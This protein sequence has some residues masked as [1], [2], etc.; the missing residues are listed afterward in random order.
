MSFLVALLISA[1]LGMER[2]SPRKLLA[3]ALAVAAILVIAQA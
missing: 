2:L 3:V 1:G